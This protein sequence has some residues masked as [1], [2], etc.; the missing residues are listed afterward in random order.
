[1]DSVLKEMGPALEEFAKEMGPKL[2]TM[3]DSVDDWA[4][5][6]VPEILP[7]GD[8]IIRRKPSAP[9]LEDAPNAP[10]IEL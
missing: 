9:P 5:Y 10:E 4:F 7:N 2:Q 1:M 8:I 6:E 3:L